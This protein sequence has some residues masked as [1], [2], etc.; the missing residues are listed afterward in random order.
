MIVGLRDEFKWVRVYSAEALGILGHL[1][2]LCSSALLLALDD[3]EDIV[4]SSAAIALVKLDPDPAVIDQLVAILI[5]TVEGRVFDEEAA[6][7]L[8]ALGPRAVKAVPVLRSKIESPEESLRSAVD[9][10]LSQIQVTHQ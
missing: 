3:E 5:S 8:G 6:M 4:R 2:T 1:A 9:Q 7:A 10:A